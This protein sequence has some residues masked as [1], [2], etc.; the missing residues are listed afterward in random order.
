MF[1][2]LRVDILK[3]KLERGMLIRKALLT[4][5][6]AYILN[7]LTH[8]SCD[9]NLSIQ[10]IIINPYP[11]EIVWY[12]LFDHIV[13]HV[14]RGCTRLLVRHWHTK[15]AMHVFDHLGV[16]I[17]EHLDLLPLHFLVVLVGL[18]WILFGTEVLD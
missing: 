11:S 8:Q 12:V 13:I 16:E 4:T 2:I 14:I 17:L 6:H 3:V 5:L 1:L 15:R 18:L 9:S 10:I 7:A